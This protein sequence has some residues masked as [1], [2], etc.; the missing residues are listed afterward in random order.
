MF[1]D[2][3]HTMEE[4]LHQLCLAL[5]CQEEDAADIM[6]QAHNCGRA[7]V[8]IASEGE[9]MRIASLLGEIGLVAQIEAAG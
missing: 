4:V 5:R 6:M 7:V 1:N 8:T 3:I 2:D 9:A